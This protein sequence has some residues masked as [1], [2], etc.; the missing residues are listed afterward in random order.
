MQAWAP[1]VRS[2]VWSCGGAVTWHTLG[3]L[4]SS[5]P[6]GSSSAWH[7]PRQLHIPSAGFSSSGEIRACSRGLSPGPARSGVHVWG[8]RS[9]TRSRHCREHGQ[10]TAAMIPWPSCCRWDG[11]GGWSLRVPALL[12]LCLCRAEP[13]Q[14]SQLCRPPVPGGNWGRNS[15]SVPSSSCERSHQPFSPAWPPGMQEWAHGRLWDN[16][17]GGT[18]ET[19]VTPE[20]LPEAAAPSSRAGAGISELQG[21]GRSLRMPQRGGEGRAPARGVLGRCGMWEPS[22]TALGLFGV[23]GAPSRSLCSSL[24]AGAA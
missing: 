8:P 10:N 2:S 16:P 20:P 18:S 9:E 12:F 7:Q 21:P 1:G 4:G 23:P 11:R 3:S 13:F 24:S 5:C 14:P 22:P 15:P 17:W 19:R 6:P